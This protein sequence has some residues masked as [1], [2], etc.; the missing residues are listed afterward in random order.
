[1]IEIERQ[2]LLRFSDGRNGEV[3]IQQSE[4]RLLTRIDVSAT[5]PITFDVQLAVKWT[6]C[7]LMTREPVTDHLCVYA[8]IETIRNFLTCYHY[9]CDVSA[10]TLRIGQHMVQ[11]HDTVGSLGITTPRVQAEVRVEKR[12]FLRARLQY[13]HKGEVVSDRLVPIFDFVFIPKLTIADLRKR[14]API[15]NTM[16]DLVQVYP[17]EGQLTPLDDKDHVRKYWRM[18]EVGNPGRVHSASLFGCATTTRQSKCMHDGTISRASRP[19]NCSAAV[20]SGLSTTR[21]IPMLAT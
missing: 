14:I 1:V 16:G 4:C 2:L 18:G 21:Q 12:G 20:A 5:D 7:D 8:A 3:K 9:Q 15:M 10:I 13:L 19:A 6:S 11:P 17:L